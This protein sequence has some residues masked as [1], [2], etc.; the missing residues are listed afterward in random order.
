MEPTNKLDKYTVAV[1][2]NEWDV[3]GHLPFEKLGKI[4]RFL[5]SKVWQRPLL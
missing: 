3:I 2:G 1:K 5:V 4:E